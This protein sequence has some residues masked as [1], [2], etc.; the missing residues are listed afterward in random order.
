MAGNTRG[1]LEGNS[2]DPTLRKL[3]VCRHNGQQVFALF[4]RD[5]LLAA[6]QVALPIQDDDPAP[7]DLSVPARLFMVAVA[8]PGRS[9]G[10]ELVHQIRSRVYADLVHD[11][12]L[13]AAG[14][15]LVA[16]LELPMQVGKIP[17]RLSDEKASELAI[18][19]I[20]FARQNPAGM[21]IP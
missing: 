10:L 5:E 18:D 3:S 12:C 9:H 20:E 1:D 13:S 8:L 11:G 2:G 19:L 4:T 15:K 16:R 21:G 6:A 7:P 17:E 14:E